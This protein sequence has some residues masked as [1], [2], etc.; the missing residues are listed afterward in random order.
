MCFGD[1]GMNNNDRFNPY[2][3]EPQP[4]WVS[5]LLYALSIVLL[6]SGW[7][8]VIY[9]NA[10]QFR[11]LA[12]QLTSVTKLVNH[13]V[14]NYA[15]TQLLF[16]QSTKHGVGV[17]LTDVAEKE[18]RL[19]FEL[20]EG[21]IRNLSL[22]TW[23]PNDQLYAYAEPN[24]GE[25]PK[26]KPQKVTLCNASDGSLNSSATVFGVIEAF[27]W[28]TA[29]SF[30]YLNNSNH[31]HVMAYTTGGEWKEQR[32]LTN[33]TS[34]PIT[35]FTAISLNTVAWEQDGII[36][37]W[38]IFKS[39][40][41]ELWK[42]KTNQLVG[43]SYSPENQK[44]II[45][46][47]NDNRTYQVSSFDPRIGAFEI[48]NR[49]SIPNISQVKWINSGRGYALLGTD[50]W[51]DSLYVSPDG[52]HSMTAAF[53][54]GHVIEFRE[55]IDRLFIFGSEGVEP[56]GIWQ[57]D[58][59]THQVRPIIPVTK[60]PL[61]FAKSVHHSS[62]T[63][64][65][66]DHEI[67]YQVWRPERISRGKKYPLII[68]QT[69]YYWSPFPVMAASSGYY[70]VKVN[71]IS[72][73]AGIDTWE[74]D[75]LAVYNELSKDVQIDL[76]R[77]FLFGHSIETVPLS[78]LAAEKPLL[79]KGIII[80]S[81]IELPDLSRTDLSAIWI[82]AGELDR[83][84]DRLPAYQAEASKIGTRTRLVIHPK[85]RHKS[86]SKAIEQAQIEEMAAFLAQY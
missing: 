59:P 65:N 64:T 24:I 45:C 79:W 76:G 4:V 69:P 3:P 73:E 7:R 1:R 8:F 22:L 35:D 75:V 58:L 6:I 68:T 54:E 48:L 31:V 18:E 81:P 38:P 36:W 53:Q 11:H 82:D 55:C 57:Y 10:G 40:P 46:A 66:G 84:L 61:N 83:R 72:W 14:P 33:L 39:D 29:D 51:G 26:G 21:Q 80:L 47:R 37:K 15:G 43:F 2:R 50:H 16:A 20:P 85:A 41:E 62:A 78:N 71:R 49:I 42:T 44:L 25:H 12:Y 27:C 28:L 30:A 34:M 86:W 5:K 9:I 23:S 60:K 67:T 70:F 13:P 56:A 74:S 52:S 32:A 77:V 17:F 63:L 19:L